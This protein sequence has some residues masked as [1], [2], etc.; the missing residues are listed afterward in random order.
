[1]N[2]VEMFLRANGYTDKD[3]KVYTRLNDSM[4]MICSSNTLRGI[5]IGTVVETFVSM[6][7]LIEID[8]QEQIMIVNVSLSD[9]RVNNLTLN[10]MDT[11]YNDRF[12]E[13]VIADM[14][15][16]MKY[17]VSSLSDT[18]KKDINA[19]LNDMIDMM[20]DINSFSLVGVSISDNIKELD[21]NFEF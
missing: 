19:V 21:R 9:L 13:D 6:Y 8:G 17:S 2:K 18:Y 11:V 16:S 7:K 12:S 1:M 3:Y 5:D 14:S 10:I 15:L 20:L 4:Y